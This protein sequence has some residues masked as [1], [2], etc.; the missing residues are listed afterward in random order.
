MPKKTTL[1][2]ADRPYKFLQEYS[3]NGGN[4]YRAAV[5]AGYTPQYSLK[6]GKKILRNA[7]SLHQDVLGDNLASRL[8]ITREE[9]VKRAKFL[10]EQ[11]RDLNVA[12]KML[13]PIAKSF[14]MDFD[15]KEEDKNTQPVINLVFDNS[16]TLPNKAQQSPEIE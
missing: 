12:H 4:I 3:K 7:L 1:T 9:V 6:E 10:L 2:K 16:T 8:G 5:H 11:D 13:K 14:D 15:D